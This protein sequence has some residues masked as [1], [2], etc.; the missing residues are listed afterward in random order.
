[1]RDRREEIIEKIK[2]MRGFYGQK[3]AKTPRSVSFIAV[4]KLFDKV[5]E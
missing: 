4:E 3:N 1:M 5:E 2:R